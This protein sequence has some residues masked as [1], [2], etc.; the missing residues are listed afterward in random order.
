MLSA[1]SHC[2]SVQPL[3]PFAYFRESSEISENFHVTWYL[4]QTN[5]V[6]AS[7]QRGVWALA[8]SSCRAATRAE[9]QLP[10]WNGFNNTFPAIIQ[11]GESSVSWDFLSVSPCLPPWWAGERGPLWQASGVLPRRA[12]HGARPCLAV[13]PGSR[14]RPRIFEDSRTSEICKRQ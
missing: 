13:G 4:S 10:S 6:T 7:W 8:H 3:L 14:G 5:A 2:I 12:L 11:C 1:H 9:V